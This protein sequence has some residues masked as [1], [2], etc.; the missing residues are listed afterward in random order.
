MILKLER[1]K[2]KMN[3]KL[4]EQLFKDI[5][6]CLNKS[7]LSYWLEYG[8]LLGFVRERD[9]IDTDFDIDFG[10]LYEEEKVNKFIE[11]VLDLGIEL[12]IGKLEDGTLRKMSKTV[13]GNKKEFA[14][15]EVCV[16]YKTEQFLFKPMNFKN[17]ELYGYRHP[18][19][20]FETLW[21]V[22]FKDKYVKIPS[23]PEE[24]LEWHYGD[25]KTPRIDISST[26][27]REPEKL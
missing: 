14:K 16:F 4:A 27:K 17:G 24:Y 11:L 5:V 26:Y 21:E 2:D 25:W 22:R 18:I 15:V 6:D 23:F 12:N 13:F 9:F 7:R 19:K 20:Y 10:I 8:T 1:G 3:K